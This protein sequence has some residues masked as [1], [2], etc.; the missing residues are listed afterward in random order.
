M[1]GER[2]KRNKSKASTMKIV[3][4]KMRKETLLKTISEMFFEVTKLGNAFK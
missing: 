3:S 1:K 2:M 4:S